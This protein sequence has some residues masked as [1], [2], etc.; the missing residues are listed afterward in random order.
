MAITWKSNQELTDELRILK[1]E[2]ADIKEFEIKA[3]EE[4]LIKKIEIYMNRLS[5]IENRLIERMGEK[6][7]P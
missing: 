6:I 4:R 5:I 1:K 7:H 3:L 2:I